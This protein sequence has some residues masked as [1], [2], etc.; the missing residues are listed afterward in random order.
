[1]AAVG[2]PRSSASPP[3]PSWYLVCRSAEVRRGA[4]LSREL[5]GR[6]IVLFRGMSGTVHALTAHCAHM[7]AHLGKGAVVG[8][9]LRCA[10]HGWE[11][12]GQGIC[13]HIPLKETI[14]AQARQ[15]AYPAA[16]RYGAVFIFN[17]PEPLF[18][19]PSFTIAD[20]EWQVAS[21]EP[22]R[23]RCPWQA[24]GANVFDMEH[25]QTAHERALR[26]PPAVERPDR[27][28]ICLRYSTRITGRRLTDRVTAWL[29]GNRIRATITC[30]GGTIITAENDIGRARSALLLGIMPTA[31]GVEVTPL[32]GVRR[33]GIAAVDRLRVAMARW[34]ISGFLQRDVAIMDEMRFHPPGPLPEGEP[35]RAYL[36]FLEALQVAH[37]AQH[38]AHSSQRDKG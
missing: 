8:D 25:L 2:K 32:F 12:D 24:V 15:A 27:Y 6:P 14:P 10:L 38:T 22:V 13:R 11:Y 4:V 34:L 26:E 9:R 29:S 37:S 16:E 7:G 36:E 30:W 28:R 19:L 31:E 33:I 23:L 20:A 17:G 5:L 3:V 18:P 1:M 21:G 35:L